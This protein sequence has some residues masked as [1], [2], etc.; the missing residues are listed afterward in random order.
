MTPEKTMCTPLRTF[1]FMA[2]IMLVTSGRLSSLARSP[3]VILLEE[4]RM[5][6]LKATLKVAELS[7]IVL[8]QVVAILVC[9]DGRFGYRC[10]IILR[11]CFIC[12]VAVFICGVQNLLLLQQRTVCE[13]SG[14]GFALLGCL[15]LELGRIVA[16][17]HGYQRRGGEIRAGSDLY[18]IVAPVPN[19]ASVINDDNHLCVNGKETLEILDSQTS[20]FVS[21]EDAI[22]EDL[23]IRIHDLGDVLSIGASTHGVDVQLVILGDGGQELFKT[24]AQFD[25]VPATSCARTIVYELESADILDSGVV[26]VLGIFLPFGN[27]GVDSG[28]DNGLVEIDDKRDIDSR[29]GRVACDCVAS[30]TSARGTLRGRLDQTCAWESARSP[31]PAYDASFGDVPCGQGAFCTC[32]RASPH[33]PRGLWSCTGRRRGAHCSR[34]V[35]MRIGANRRSVLV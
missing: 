12:V 31:R 6:R 3:A 5:D 22:G 35:M 24:R 20:T 34:P 13:L 1:I 14:D 30:S 32:S 10:C 33:H 4:G 18:E 26:W 17:T 8:Q 11:G 2:A 23:A 27:G 25:I 19:I 15:F 21:A 16:A 7:V 29:S 9:L 28:L